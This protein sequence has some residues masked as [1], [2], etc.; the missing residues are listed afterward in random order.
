MDMDPLHLRPD[1]LTYEL[2]VRGVHNLGNQRQKTL[3][4]RG[5]LE[6]ER[7][8]VEK[9]PED[10]SNV[11]P[12]EIEIQ[13]CNDLYNNIIGVAEADENS[14]VGLSEC[15]SRL[16]HLGGR[17]NR[18]KPT[19][20]ID[21]INVNDLGL[22]TSNSLK[23]I[24]IRLDSGVPPPTQHIPPLSPTVNLIND[25]DINLITSDLGAAGISS[26]ARSNINQHQQN[27]G[28][29]F[30]QD[31]QNQ[32]KRTS[33]RN[34]ARTPEAFRNSC[35]SMTGL[36]SMFNRTFVPPVQ[37]Q[38]PPT[39]FQNSN[40]LNLR[41]N[42]GQPVRQMEGFGFNRPQMRN[43]PT[44]FVHPFQEAHQNPCG[45]CQ[46]PPNRTDPPEQRQFFDEWQFPPVQNPMAARF[47]KTVPVY[48]WRVSFSGN[49]KGAHLYD[50]LSK[51]SMYKRS[52]QITDEDLLLSIGH[53]LTGKALQWYVAEGD[54]F[55]NLPDLVEAMRRRFLP[56]DYD[57]R[58]QL[59]ISQRQQKASESFAE[60]MTH[61]KSLFKC[62]SVPMTEAQQVCILKKNLLQKYAIGVANAPDGSLARLCEICVRLDDVFNRDSNLTMPFQETASSLPRPF[63]RS[64]GRPREA[65]LI[66]IDSDSKSECAEEQEL[67]A[68]HAS[69]RPNANAFVR[70]RPSNIANTPSSSII[71][72]W[73]CH[74]SGH[75]FNKCDMEQQG[76]FCFKCGNPDV[77]VNNCLKCKGN[78]EQNSGVQEPVASSPLQGSQ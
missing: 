57:Y 19:T 27:A 61:M 37:H 71:T 44:Y 24:V 1:E 14:V 3:A 38:P 66:D 8:G 62:L 43:H 78:A 68:M 69:R 25:E 29:S 67:C 4:L 60:Y 10:S 31:F 23:K 34:S 35:P 36:G 6:K 42:S 75:V 18:I 17:L 47:R 21:V 40:V 2:L 11:Y 59:E 7:S 65:N 28:N 50:F 54:M 55:H 52:E 22:C 5:L 64:F 9:A 32:P 33:Q 48:Q 56:P 72:C 53:L 30:S 74:R 70:P 26:A 12:A 49:G 63:G 39:G 46:Q 51:I 45:A 41:S 58:L 13:N 76:R 16:R 77:I 20:E 15:V 73:N